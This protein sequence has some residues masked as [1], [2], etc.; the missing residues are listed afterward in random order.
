[1]LENQYLCIIWIQRVH[2]NMANITEAFYLENFPDQ[3][4]PRKLTSSV[5]KI[6]QRFLVGLAITEVFDSSRRKGANR[7]VLLFEAYERHAKVLHSRF[8]NMLPVVPQGH[9]MYEYL[10]RV[11][12]SNA[13][14]M[15][16]GDYLWD[17]VWE[18]LSREIK[19]RFIPAYHNK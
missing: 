11:S 19:C 7:N 5:V 12:F 16:S 1:V 15:V 14:S 4:L 3:P 18:T 2:F 8:G 6:W 17:T 10:M 9:T 13:E